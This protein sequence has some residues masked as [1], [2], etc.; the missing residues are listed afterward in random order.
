L[1]NVIKIKQMKLADDVPALS[2]AAAAQLLKLKFLIANGNP[3]TLVW[4]CPRENRLT[5]ARECLHEVEQVGFIYPEQGLP[6]LLMMGDELCVDAILALASTLPA[7]GKLL[8]YR[9]P[10]PISYTN[11]AKTTA[12][13]LRL[14]FK[15]LTDMVLFDGIGYVVIVADIRPN[16]QKYKELAIDL[17]RKYRL[18]AFGII[19]YNEQR[20][21]IINVYV[22]G[23]GTFIQE[24]GSGS[25]S[26]ATSIVTGWEEIIQPTGHSITVKR[27]AE[28]IT[29]EAE[30][31][32]LM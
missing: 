23:T 20:Q 25:G 30:V 27:N 6:K 22:A 24:T 32:P 31:V 8:A 7:N 28:D 13:T 5:V 11:R 10:E 19:R 16:L 21:I 17:A 9:V 1:K 18:P 4:N 29:V 12:I 3:T 14:P 2:T 15:H 26:I